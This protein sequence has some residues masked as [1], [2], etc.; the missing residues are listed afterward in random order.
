MKTTAF[1][2]LVCISS[3]TEAHVITSVENVG[4]SAFA[5]ITEDD[6]SLW[7]FTM[8]DNSWSLRKAG[9]SSNAQILPG[10]SDKNIAT[11]EY[12]PAPSASETSN[13][14]CIQVV[15]NGKEY[16][17]EISAHKL[18]EDYTGSCA[19]SPVAFLPNELCVILFTYCSRADDAC[20]RIV[21]F[22]L[23]HEKTVSS[24]DI[25]KDSCGIPERVLD[26]RSFLISRDSADILFYTSLS[27]FEPQSPVR[28]VNRIPVPLLD[29]VQRMRDPFIETFDISVM[30]DDMVVLGCTE[31]NL[32]MREANICPT[33][34]MAV[35][36]K[37]IHSSARF[38][39][40]DIV[41]A[42]IGNVRV[43]IALP[44]ALWVWNPSSEAY[45]SIILN[46]IS[47]L[48]GDPKRD[49]CGVLTEDGALYYVQSDGRVH[50]CAP[51]HTPN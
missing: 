30:G 6:N 1:L 43:F 18:G 22:D 45:T 7:V 29:Q 21:V 46:S 14:A 31:R 20:G 44:N 36:G 32:E 15:N 8:P 19:L 41:D 37:K 9:V 23:V 40:D 38:A 34:P 11:V 50:A 51:M 12:R 33:L 24:R 16:K 47:R 5:C 49:G 48:V 10:S 13:I 42:V 39:N 4:P 2:L 3:G 27:D 35:Y 28:W 25:P 17:A 26:R